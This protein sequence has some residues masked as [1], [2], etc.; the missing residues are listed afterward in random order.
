MVF[1][2][3]GGVG[4]AFLPLL[5]G[6]VEVELWS[7]ARNFCDAAPLLLGQVGALEWQ[8]ISSQVTLLQ[9]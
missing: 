9:H 7:K 3:N 8:K 5:G 1:P 4:F 2:G 6:R